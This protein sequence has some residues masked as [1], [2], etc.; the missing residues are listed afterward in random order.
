MSA[1]KYFFF[2]FVYL[3]FFL[4]FNERKGRKGLK[5]LH[6]ALSQ[7]NLIAKKKIEMKEKKEN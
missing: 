6:K 7:D 3:F 2:S 4:F 1:K 5:Y